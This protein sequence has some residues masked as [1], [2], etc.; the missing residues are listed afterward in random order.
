MTQL[1][2]AKCHA[3]LWV[4]GPNGTVCERC[5][6]LYQPSWWYLTTRA[7]WLALA[8]IGLGTLVLKACGKL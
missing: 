8:S 2:C 7:L 4:P 5:E 6:N 3:H 1:R